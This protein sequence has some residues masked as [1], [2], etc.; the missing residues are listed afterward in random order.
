MRTALTSRLHHLRVLALKG[1]HLVLR[2]L[3]APPE[4]I[5]ARRLRR[6][7]VDSAQS[8]VRGALESTPIAVRQESV[9]IWTVRDWSVHVQLESVLG[10][11]LRARGHRVSFAT[12]GGGLEICDRVNTWEGPPMPCRSCSKYVLDSLNHHGFQPLAMSDYWTDDDWPELDIL[13]LDELLAA[14][15]NGIPL[16]HLVE[17]P[18]KWFL[19]GESLDKD[20]LA[21]QTVRAFLRSARRIAVSVGEILDREQPDQVIVLNGLFL[22]ES[23]ILELCRR[24][25]ISFVTYERAL[26]LDSF[27]FSRDSI[28]ALYR[29][30]EAWRTAM[31]LP[32]TGPEL[33]ELHSHLA[34]RRIGGDQSDNYWEFIRRP[35]VFSNVESSRAVLFTNLVWDS[36]VIGQDLGFDSIVAWILFVIEQYRHRPDHQLV[37]RVHPAEVRL[38]GRETRERMESAISEHLTELPSNVTLIAAEDPVDS[39]S[40]MER[41]DFGLV[42]S[43]TTGLEMALLGK[44]VIVA[45][46]TH[47]RG[48][49]FTIDVST[50]DEL[51]QAIATQC[52]PSSRLVPDQ[53][54][55]ERYAH[56][57]FFKSMYRDLGVSEPIRGLCSVDSR[58]IRRSIEA[59]EGDLSRVVDSIETKGK[60]GF[61]SDHPV[62]LNTTLAADRMDGEAHE[63]PD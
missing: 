27:V 47:Y 52:D 18:V 28:C 56:L 24:R 45:A 29:V 25:G 57:V 36:A 55:A 63:L 51:S 13:T 5:P 4:A 6:W 22:F 21:F 38:A 53:E 9:L 48:K 7:S 60:F 23:I 8:S 58:R 43:S 17:I 39:Y 42:Y 15:W 14:E 1:V 30:D 46:E 10:Q 35:S 61:V 54:L 49:G 26:I 16:G 59:H 19:L 2:E 40:L 12:C 41:A 37:I 11:A 34:Q 50:P 62:T 32:L 33:A 3:G 44:P 20:P 31:A